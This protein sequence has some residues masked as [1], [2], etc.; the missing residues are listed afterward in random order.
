MNFKGRIV[1]K[2]KVG[3][4]YYNKNHRFL[5]DKVVAVTDMNHLKAQDVKDIWIEFIWLQRPNK[6][7]QYVLLSLVE[8]HWEEIDEGITDW[9]NLLE[10]SI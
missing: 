3:K 10:S 5:Y 6:G 1:N 4:I 9:Q 7:S 2:I 8:Q